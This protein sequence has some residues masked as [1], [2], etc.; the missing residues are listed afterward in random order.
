M[1]SSNHSQLAVEHGKIVSN[2][3]IPMQSI[4]LD[5][6]HQDVHDAG[7]ETNGCTSTAIEDRSYGIVTKLQDGFCG[8]PTSD[9]SQ[10]QPQVRVQ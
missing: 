5:P 1:N 3:T 10:P 4:S 2:S 9:V 6:D 8:I 7:I